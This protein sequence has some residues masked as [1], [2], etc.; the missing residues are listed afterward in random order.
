MS[1]PTLFDLPP[2]P[3]RRA[4]ALLPEG[5]CY[6]PD[7]VTEAEEQR[8]VRAFETLPFKPFEFHGYEGARRVVSFGWRYDFSRQ[9]LE[10][11]APIPAFLLPLRDAVAAFTGHDPATFQQAMVLEYRPGAG[12]GWHRDRP[13]FEDIAGVSLLSACPFRLR[14]KQPD[15]GWARATLKAEPRS[16][17]LLSGPARTDWEHSIAP[18]ETLRYSVTFRTF[19]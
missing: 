6:R 2:A 12:I 13:L 10:H 9:A 19:R 1:Q 3:R 17:Y 15:G 14:Q 5:L 7:L 16:A 8:L 11:A 18:V 4:T